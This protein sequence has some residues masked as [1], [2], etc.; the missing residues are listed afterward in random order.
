[1]VPEPNSLMAKSYLIL[2]EHLRFLDRSGQQ[3][4][5]SILQVEVQ[6]AL[7]SVFWDVDSFY[8]RGGIYEWTAPKGE[9][10]YPSTDVAKQLD[11]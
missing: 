10:S 11:W 9:L 6:K 4:S 2:D 3:P 7:A 5:G 8:E 1:M